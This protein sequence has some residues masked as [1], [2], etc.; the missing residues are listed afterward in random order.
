MAKQV[1]LNPVFET[2][3]NRAVFIDQD[4][5]VYPRNIPMPENI[6]EVIKFL[7]GEGARLQQDI[8]NDRGCLRIEGASYVLSGVRTLNADW[9]FQELKQ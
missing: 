4:I 6:T 3:I 5:I 1:Y 8:I 7:F 9:T 2:K